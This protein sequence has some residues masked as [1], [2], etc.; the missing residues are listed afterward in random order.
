MLE[1]TSKKIIVYPA[2]GIEPTSIFGSSTGTIWVGTYGAGL[3]TFDKT[4]GKLIS[5][6]LPSDKPITDAKFI[7]HLVEDKE[8]K[9]W[10]T[11][12]GGLRVIDRKN[13]RVTTYGHDASD[14][15]SLSSNEF[16]HIY[17]DTSGNIWISTINGLNYFNQATKTFTRYKIDYSGKYPA[18][19]NIN[20]VYADSTGMLWVSTADG[21]AY[22]D[23][24]Q[25]KIQ[26]C[27]QNASKKV[28]SRYAATGMY[29]DRKGNLWIST[30]G[31]GL[32]ALNLKKFFEPERKAEFTFYTE[33]SGLPTNLVT[34]IIADE[35]GNLWLSTLQGICR[36]T[37][38][39]DGEPH[40]RVYNTSDGLKTLSTIARY[41]DKN[42]WMYFQNE[43]N[44]TVFH[45]DSLRD[46]PFVPP[47]V[48]TDFQLFNK[49]VAIGEESPLKKAIS[50][51]KEVTLSHDQSTF[52]LAFAALNFVW[53]TKNQYAF[54]LENY[55]K[56]WNYVGNDKVARYVNVP[57]GKY[58]FKVKAS[59][60]D[61]VWNN[62]GVSLL[63]TI[64]PPYYQTWWF[65]M[66][67]FVA[68]AG[69]A[70]AFYRYR[71]G[72]V[73][74]E[75]QLKAAF[76][77]QLAEVSMMALRAQMNPHFLFNSLNSINHFIV[78]NRA[79]EASEYLTKF[80]RLIRLILSNSQNPT[81]ALAKELEALRLYI[82]MEQL[83]FENRFE[84]VIDIEESLETEF[85]DIPP[86]LLQP[87]VENAIWH[88]LLHKETP[89]RLL[90]Q[91]YR[92]EA[93][94]YCLIEDNGVGRRKAAELK[95][96]SVT[97]NKSLG[98]QIT[99]SRVAMLNRLTQGEASVQITDLSDQMGNATGT[100]VV[101]KIPIE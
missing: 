50:E 92:K 40:I 1:R 90:L 13:S 41:K 59:N 78:R 32:V 2:S 98:M 95:S 17:V 8:G 49:P 33:K 58:I 18:A 31:A 20:G 16:H 64:R 74:H 19:N 72:Q 67:I 28:L 80:S 39:N 94:L 21:I 12:E 3:H 36:F 61:G 89:G 96:K 83:R 70:Y 45:P 71:I 44:L 5:Y 84:Y 91:V 46:N 24:E 56:E 85:I 27:E 6:A 52:S 34:N 87:Y 55:E 4:T 42:G 43:N 15:L 7:G 26:L 38:S 66:L 54:N 76:D 9:L 30:Y 29:N 10:A 60:N 23:K 47:I 65:R 11:T 35:K 99:S 69:L 81:V 101:M 22:L 75:E 48:L 68:I 93:F 73:R 100:R 25:N 62:Q 97:S 88:G 57:P 77:K 37:P 79:E 51:T 63:V 82:Q 53:P 14:T 86:M